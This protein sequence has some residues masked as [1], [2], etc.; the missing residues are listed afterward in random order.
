MYFWSQAAMV[1][2][3]RKEVFFGNDFQSSLISSQSVL[4]QSHDISA[5]LAERGLCPISS[6]CVWNVLFRLKLTFFTAGIR[7]AHAGSLCPDS[8]LCP[9][10]FWAKYLPQSCKTRHGMEPVPRL[11][12]SL[13]LR[14]HCSSLPPPSK[15]CMCR[16]EEQLCCVRPRV[17]VEPSILSPTMADN[18]CTTHSLIGRQMYSDMSPK[19]LPVSNNLC[20][21]D[22]LRKTYHLCWFFLLCFYFIFPY[23]CPS[24]F[25]KGVNFEHPQHPAAR[26]STV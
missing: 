20:F 22:F 10:S 4:G 23:I 18:A 8:C 9:I 15:T 11:G 17:F 25:G 2:N 12:C 7:G 13:W 19:R 21:G 3:Q 16:R 6:F 14:V 26:T 24:V 1:D 5:M